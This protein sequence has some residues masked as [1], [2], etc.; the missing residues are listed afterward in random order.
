MEITTDKEL[1]KTK[2]DFLQ[3]YHWL[4][5]IYF[6]FF[7]LIF[8]KIFLSPGS[9]TGGDWSFPD[10]ASQAKA[11][12]DSLSHTWT[13]TGNIFGARQLSSVVIVVIG[14]LLWLSKMGIS[15]PLLMKIF[16]L[17][18]FAIAASNFNLFARYIGIKPVPAAIGGVFFVLTPIF[19]NYTLMGWFYALIA[20]SLIPLFVYL[21]LRAI[22]EKNLKY[23]L[24]AALVFFLAI[25]SQSVVW[26]GFIIMALIF[27]YGLPRKK[28]GFSF[29]CGLTTIILF[30]LLNSFWLAILLI[31]PDQGAS[32]SD[33]VKSTISIGT[34]E[35]LSALNILR[36]WG[37]LFNFQFETSYPKNISIFSFALPFLALLSFLNWKKF[38]RHFIYI[39]LI[40]FV[41]IFFFLI[42]R[43]VI[44]KLP[45]SNLIRDIARFLVLANF[46]LAILATVSLDFL[47]GFKSIIGK[48]IFVLSV[49]L[50]IMY[51][52]P[53]FTGEMYSKPKNQ[54]DFRLRTRVWPSEYGLLNQKL[55]EEEGYKRALCLPIGGLVSINNSRD[56]RGMFQEAPDVYAGFSPIASMVAISDRDRG[57]S[58]VIIDAISNQ[59]LKNQDASELLRLASS[60]GI[61]FLVY[62]RDLDMFGWGEKEKFEFEQKLRNEVSA[63]R[64]DIYLDKGAILAISLKS[65]RS[66]IVV[67]GESQP[68][69]NYRKINP[70]I[71]EIE[72]K[73]I[74]GDFSLDFNEN[75]NQYWKLV[76]KAGFFAKQISS[77]HYQAD[78]GE[79]GNEYNV[80]V[81]DLEV[82]GVLTK[83]NDGSSAKFYLLF[84]PDRYNLFA[85]FLSCLTFVVI[86]LL[87]FIPIKWSA[88]TAR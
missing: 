28:F 37:G 57:N 52:L 50:L 54:A 40:L 36:L 62:R 47:Y 72:V 82:A 86:I 4:F 38:G 73:N 33:L 12:F 61:D 60:A 11:F 24:L 7:A 48:I 22:D 30:L 19:F 58:S 67:S 5:L 49:V 79:F 6:V 77:E 78:K 29:I 8:Y 3:K 59:A 25:Q 66:L 81:S 10:N 85:I 34:S 83:T 1:K 9:L 41:P 42:G 35:K 64:A 18:I 63:G 20:L 14:P 80:S 17:L 13:R 51:A 43:D 76:D 46:S 45:F 2:S 44:G 87:I 88:K 27:G 26:Y 74:T 23:I 56:F 55:E 70:A 75:Y 84:W 31:F 53:F 71:Y 69:V 39:I 21:F 15:F 32:G 65:V 68:V 16:L